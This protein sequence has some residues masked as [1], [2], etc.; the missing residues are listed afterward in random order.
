LVSIHKEQS[1]LIATF[2]VSTVLLFVIE[3]ILLAQTRNLIMGNLFGAISAFFVLTILVITLFSCG[4]AVA[5]A[6]ALGQLFRCLHPPVG[7]VAL[8]CVIYK[9]NL[10]FLYPRYYLVL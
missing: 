5:I 8:L 1:L 7:A 4:L 9:A 6:V 2:G 3:E 10:K